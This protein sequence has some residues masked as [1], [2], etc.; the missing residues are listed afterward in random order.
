M[1]SLITFI[2]DITQR[3]FFPLCIEVFEYVLYAPAIARKMIERGL[4]RTVMEVA[5]QRTYENIASVQEFAMK[6]VTRAAEIEEERRMMH[7]LGYES[8]IVFFLKSNDVK[9]QVAAL[10]AV[11]GLCRRPTNQTAFFDL[12][13]H[14]IILFLME[15]AASDVREWAFHAIAF[16][17]FRNKNIMNSMVA[18]GLGDVIYTALLDEEETWEVKGNA[19]LC[20]ILLRK[21]EQIRQ[22]LRIKIAQVNTIFTP[23]IVYPHRPSFIHRG[24]RSPP[25]PLKKSKKFMQIE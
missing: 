23:S 5:M 3:K 11:A 22:R 15:G 10:Q 19:L 6:T 13:A 20:A 16:L 4:Y 2:S 14:R 7:E 8:N 18:K 21:D 25:P 24:L 9:V 1:T 17:I 12:G